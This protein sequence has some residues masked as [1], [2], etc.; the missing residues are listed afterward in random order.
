VDPQEARAA[1]HQPIH[2]RVAISRRSMDENTDD[3][4]ITKKLIAAVPYIA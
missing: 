1:A 3:K 4:W 2:V